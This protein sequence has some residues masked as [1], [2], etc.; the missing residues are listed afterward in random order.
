MLEVKFKKM[1]ANAVM[2]TYAKPGDAGMDLTAV[3]VIGVDTGEYGYLEY[4]T[5]LAFEIPEGFVGKVYPRSSISKTGLIQSNSVGIIDSGYR[6]SVTIRYKA[7][8]GTKV[9]DVGDRIGQLIIEPVPQISFIEAEELST[10]ER[11][12]GGYGSTGN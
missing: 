5:G 3:S 12:E 2:P 4:D 11:G 7:I 6:G 9:Y 8:P 1:H 10:T